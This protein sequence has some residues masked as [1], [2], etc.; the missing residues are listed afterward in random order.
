MLGTES[1]ADFFSFL[2]QRQELERKEIVIILRR[3]AEKRLAL[4]MKGVQNNVFSS[5]NTVTK[6]VAAGATA[7]FPCAHYLKL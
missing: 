1:V 4:V 2:I 6:C 7:Q 3:F 5:R